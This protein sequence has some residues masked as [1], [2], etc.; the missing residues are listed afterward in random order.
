MWVKTLKTLPLFGLMLLSFATGVF[1]S[2]YDCHLKNPTT[3]ICSYYVLGKTTNTNVF[4]VDVPEHANN[5]AYAQPNVPFYVYA[6]DA[7][8]DSLSFTLASS[9]K[10]IADGE[11]VMDSETGKQMNIM[12]MQLMRSIMK[13]PI[14]IVKNHLNKVF[15]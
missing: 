14:S 5:S 10:R 15:P 13:K 12:L 1:A 9:G 4:V 2:D 8:S 3:P 7:A 6:P 11:E